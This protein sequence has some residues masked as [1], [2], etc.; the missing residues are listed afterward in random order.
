MKIVS[1][2][3]DGTGRNPM[4]FYVG[5]EIVYSDGENRY[6]GEHSRGID[7]ILFLDCFK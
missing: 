1:M 2:I 7:A 4:V 3:F 6:R 5:V